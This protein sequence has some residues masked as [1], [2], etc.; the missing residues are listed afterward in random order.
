MKT[1]NIQIDSILLECIEKALEPLGYNARESIFRL[2]EARTGIPRK[3][4]ISNSDAFLLHLQNLF[5][6]PATKTLEM[7]MKREIIKRFDLSN[8]A[9]EELSELIKEVKQTIQKSNE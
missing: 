2:F 4:I 9:N 8:E 3:K 6:K 5:G 1:S 7:A